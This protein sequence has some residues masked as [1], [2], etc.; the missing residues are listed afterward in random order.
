MTK[1]ESRASDTP[2]LFLTVNYRQPIDNDAASLS[3][4]IVAY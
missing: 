1:E 2:P 4:R 3:D